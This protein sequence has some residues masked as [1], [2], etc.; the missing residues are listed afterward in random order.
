MLGSIADP[1]TA[2][3]ARR[4]MIVQLF[5]RNRPGPE[6]AMAS[7]RA[8][9]ALPMVDEM[10]EP[11]KKPRYA[12][13]CV[14]IFAAQYRPDPPAVKF[15]M[16]DALPHIKFPVGGTAPG[17]MWLL[18]LVDT[19]AGLSL[20]C[21]SY[22]HA[23]YVKYPHLVERFEEFDMD[24]TRGPNAP[25]TIG[26]IHDQS[27]GPEITASITYKTPFN[28]DGERA[29][30]T[31]GLGDHVAANTILGLTFIKAT[32]LTLLFDG[33]DSAVSPLLGHAFKVEYCL[34]H[35]ADS[36]PNLDPT[37][38]SVLMAMRCARVNPPTLL[39]LPEGPV[40]NI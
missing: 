5:A 2:P 7:G 32:K 26:G 34:P 14:P 35:K 3:L 9:N 10:D 17:I 27:S 8:L 23:I 19:G 37:I 4:A 1:A 6:N 22:H 13:I 12:L 21:R 24:E 29:T 30:L 20:G 25:F 16:T 40:N 31:L 38:E 18:A 11:N 15:P 36:A 33:S 39:S 28:C